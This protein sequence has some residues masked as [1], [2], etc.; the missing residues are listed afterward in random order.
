MVAVRAQFKPFRKRLAHHSGR[1]RQVRLQAEG[2]GGD[3]EFAGLL[4]GESGDLAQP[5]GR[6]GGEFAETEQQQAARGE[7]ATRIE[8]RRLFET[9]TVVGRLQ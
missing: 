5:V 3:L 9:A 2:A 7:G 8:Q 6:D 1:Q 4:H